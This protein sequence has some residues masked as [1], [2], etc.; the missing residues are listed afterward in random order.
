MRTEIG[1]RQRRKGIPVEIEISQTV[2]AVLARET[3]DKKGAFA[4]PFKRE[5]SL[6]CPPLRAQMGGKR[7]LSAVF[8]A[9]ESYWEIALNCVEERTCNKSVCI[10]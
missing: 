5:F 7:Q 6:S 1:I 4:G 3:P 9:S 10:E 8:P 2:A